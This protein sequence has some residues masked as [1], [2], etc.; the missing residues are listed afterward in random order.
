MKIFVLT[1]LICFVSY[2]HMGLTPPVDSTNSGGK[3]H[4]GF[5]NLGGDD[6]EASVKL[7]KSCLNSDVA[8]YSK[9]IERSC[10]SNDSDPFDLEEFLDSGAELMTRNKLQAYAA[11]VISSNIDLIKP[12]GTMSDY[13]PGN[14]TCNDIPAQ[15]PAPHLEVRKSSLSVENAV[16]ASFI[17]TEMSPNASDDYNQR[18]R[19]NYPYL[20]KRETLIPTGISHDPQK[21]ILDTVKRHLGNAY[22]SDGNMFAHSTTM[23][24]LDAKMTADEEAK[25]EVEEAVALAQKQ[26]GLY[27]YSQLPQICY[28]SIEKIADRFPEIFDQF[29][30]DLPEAQSNVTRYA[31]CK[32]KFYYDP[33]NFDSDCDGVKDSDDVEPADPFSPTSKH[34]VGDKNY[35]NPPFTGNGLK[36]VSKVGNTIKVKRQISVNLSGLSAQDKEKVMGQIE[37][38]RDELKKSVEDSYAGFSEMNPNMSAYNLDFD[39]EI[40]ESTNLRSDFSVHK[41][42]CSTCKVY[43]NDPSGRKTRIP[44][45]TCRSDFT[46]EM[47]AGLTDNNLNPVAKRRRWFSQ[48]DAANLTI[49]SAGNCKTIKHELLHKLGLSDEYVADYYPFNLVGEHDSLMH[50]GHQIYPR[51]IGDIISP[52]KCEMSE[53]KRGL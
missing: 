11:S 7:R 30:V 3:S 32:E 52:W 40:N 45:D 39:M 33:D 13:I 34:S 35:S 41:C 24:A 27:L 9:D 20:F 46:A 22:V 23:D 12:L 49:S 21:N 48:A 15:D 1:T 5:G 28:M 8:R 43:Y 38:C 25:K 10:R 19:R 51:Q 2:A 14:S 44:K 50:G 4:S 16:S 18:I 31:L 42:W 47:N 17:D 36:E 6:F 37:S 53:G 29:L 26:Y